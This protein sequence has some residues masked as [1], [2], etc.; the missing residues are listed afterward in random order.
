MKK[1]WIIIIM[2]I[3]FIAINIFFSLYKDQ[4][5]YKSNYKGKFFPKYYKKN[6]KNKF[7][8]SQNKMM[9]QNLHLFKDYLIQN[10]DVNYENDKFY[11]FDL[12]NQENDFDNDYCKKIFEKFIFCLNEENFKYSN[13]AKCNKILDN[14][15]EELEKCTFDFNLDFDIND[16]YKKLEENI[17]Y[18]NFSYYN[19]FIND[20]KED[21]EMEN[22][23]LLFENNENDMNFHEKSKYIM[24]Y[25]DNYNNKNDENINKDCIEYGLSKEEY[26]ICTK[27]E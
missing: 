25:D 14:E 27:Y 1:R 24:A 17:L 18:L 4:I 9:S 15:I 6:R 16:Y 7:I 10:F 23:E 21:D 26:L 2:I 3:L 5:N 12:N 8:K 13:N 11:F 22:R 19:D 20:D